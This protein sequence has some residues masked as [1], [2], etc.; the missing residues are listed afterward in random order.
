[1]SQIARMLGIPRSTLH[2]WIDSDRR[3][4]PTREFQAALEA[5]NL[6]SFLRAIARLIASRLDDGPPAR[7]F[8]PLVRLFVELMRDVFSHRDREDKEPT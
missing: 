4:D 6:E 3:T 2:R 1:M 8:L 7:E 5:G